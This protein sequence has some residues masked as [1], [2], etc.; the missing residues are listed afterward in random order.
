MT[1]EPSSDFSKA[2]RYLDYWN[3]DPEEWSVSDWDVYFINHTPGATKLL[4]HQSLGIE[5]ELLLDQLPATSYSYQ[6]AFDMRAALKDIKKD[7]ANIE[8]WKEYST[9]LGKLAIENRCEM[10]TIGIRA[11]TRAAATEFPSEKTLK[12]KFVEPHTPEHQIRTV[13]FDEIPLRRNTIS[14]KDTESSYT[15]SFDSP[16]SEDFIKVKARKKSYYVNY[17]VG[18]GEIEWNLEEDSIRWIVNQVDISVICMEYRDSVIQKCYSMEILNADEE[19]ALN[20]IFL[21]Q[22]ENQQG[23][24]EHFDDELW[25]NIFSEIYAQYPYVAVPEGVFNLCG[26]V[27]KIG[28]QQQEFRQR[29]TEIKKFLKNYKTDGELEEIM[30]NILS[31]FADSYQSLFS[32]NNKIEDTHSHNYVDPIIKSFFP[33]GKKTVT[34]WANRT[35]E[36]SAQMKKRFDPILSGSKPDLTIRTTNPKKYAELMFAEIKPPNARVDLINQDLVT[37]GKTMRASKDKL[38]KEGVDL[39]VSGLHVIGYIGRCY[40]MD[41]PYDGIYRMALIGE[42]IFPESP[43]TW[44]TLMNVFQV[45]ATVQDLVNKE[46]TKYQ[47]FTRSRTTQTISTNSQKL[48][49]KD[50]M[51]FHSPMKVPV[52]S[53]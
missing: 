4:A 6:K 3:R 15:P 7:S 52:P 11:S 48:K 9:K 1:S 17:F 33:E 43:T 14:P 26:S 12:R 27:L 28:C 30:H 35:S 36:S 42:F 34:D 45:M 23:L 19:L 13:T 21:L 53:D 49:I 50:M 39:I 8:L 44:G 2:L 16:V 25:Q 32:K 24:R 29:R 31:S 40:V 5:L 22:E 20:H 51:F 46:A 37:L 18:P 47:S 10:L 38:L 41:L